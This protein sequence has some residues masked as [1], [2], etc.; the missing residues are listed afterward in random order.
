MAGSPLPE[1]Y[2]YENPAAKIAPAE[3]AELMRSVGWNATSPR[4]MR[5]EENFRA[6]GISFVDAA[7]R[8]AAGELVGFGRVL[9]LGA[10]GELC[11]FTVSPAH[12]HKG[13]GK[14]IIDE[15]LR[16]AEASGIR[17]FY[18]PYLTTTNTLRSYYE[19]LGFQE[20]LLGELV[21]GPDPFQI[22]QRAPRV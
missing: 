13:I 16:R 18:M 15:R 2:R 11:D 17:S 7:V 3:R 5:S 20:T 1:G 4:I 22:A 14:A 9:Q 10:N 12:Q 8:D 21:R 19:E 6:R